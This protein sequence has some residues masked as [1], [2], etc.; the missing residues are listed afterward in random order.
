MHIPFACL[1]AA[2]AA[3]LASPSRAQG[4]LLVLN[5]TDATLSFLAPDQP[6][7]APLAVVGTGVGP[8]ELAV[9]PGG[10]RA[11]VTNYGTG[12]PG[13]SLTVIDLTKRLPL[14]TLDLGRHRR[15]H[16]I[17]FR[18]KGRVLVTCEASQA[19]IEVD[20]KER[21]VVREFATD[22]KYAHMVVLAPDGG[23]AFVAN[24]GSGSLSAFDLEAGTLL[25]HVATGAGS[26]GLAVT[27]D[28]AEVWVGNR[29]G[30]SLSIVDTQKLAVLATLPCPGFPIR[31]QVTPDGSRALVSCAKAGEVAVYDVPGRKQ[32]ARLSLSVT[33]EE[34]ERVEHGQRL[35][36]VDFQGS[37][38]PVGILIE[39]SGKRAYV[40]NTNADVVSVL[41]L[42]RLAL[43]GRLRAG[44]E[45]DGLAWTARP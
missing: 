34:L 44:R 20:L 35:F 29:D 38:V 37:P 14:D 2:L 18:G 28:G 41:D 8:H 3:L 36:G 31:V 24:I 9:E 4:E 17:A 39:P 16:G 23:R 21:A 33:P 10:A 11:V 32:L 43:A 27:P 6:A 13:S 22:Q 25:G 19:L 26:E 30:D 1:A 42:E 7:G 45:P 15:P 5:K 40:A 12:R